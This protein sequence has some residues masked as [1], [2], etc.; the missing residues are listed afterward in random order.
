MKG[1]QCFRCQKWYEGQPKSDGYRRYLGQPPYDSCNLILQVTQQGS[2]NLLDLC[3]DCVISLCSL[4]RDSHDRNYP[5][6]NIHKAKEVNCE[7]PKL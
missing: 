2:S 1:Y 6:G 3:D 4:F 5:M 7:L